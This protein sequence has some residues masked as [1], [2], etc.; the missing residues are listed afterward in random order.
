[1]DTGPLITLAAA[2]SLDFLL[3]PG[4]PVCI[5]DAVL[6]EA[7]QDA[8]ALGASAILDWAQA[9]SDAV[10][11]LS[12]ETFF[13][14]VQRREAD[15]GWREK[16]LGERAAIEAIHDAIHLAPG[17]RALLMTEDDRALR[18]V[19]VLEAELTRL[20]IPVTTRDFLGAL[21]A[22]RRIQSAEEVYRRAE[23]AGRLAGRR[24][25]L[26]DQHQRARDA[27]LRLLGPREPP[28]ESDS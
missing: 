8:T 1:M 10:R 7:T 6:Y 18:R 26:R 12:T 11:T 15:P 23:D 17:E 16:D 20:M 24:E 3:Y 9:N 27:V 13:N 21:E 25:A 14:F 22:A 4:V 5:A 19:L 2:D 28:I